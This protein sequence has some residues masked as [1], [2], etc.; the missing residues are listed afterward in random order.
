VTEQWISIEAVRTPV[1][2]YSSGALSALGAS[3]RD[4]GQRHPIT[5]WKDGTLIS[6][7]RR[8]RAALLLGSASM[9]AV[10]VDTI[11]DAAKRLLTD[12]QDDY[13]ALPMK[14]SEM[15]R[16]WELLRRLDEPAAKIRADEAR[17]RG[18]ELRRQTMRGQRPRG[19]TV[20]SSEDY[21]L[22]VLAPPFGLSESTARRLWA[23]Y[24]HAVGIANTTAEKADKARV[25]LADIDAGESSI[26]ANYERLITSRAAPAPRSRT[27]PVPV[28]AADAAR[29]R[30]AWAR[31]LPQLEG[32]VSGLVELGPPNAELTWDEVGPV[33]TRLAAVRRELEKMIKQMR[34]HNKS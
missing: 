29:Q 28:E 9:R 3:L 8:H 34:E 4:D 18:V 16:L 17:R 30:L 11:E 15:C 27:R 13:L 26:S 10:F 7:F 31:S 6:G 19:R 12:G 2:R 1:V 21:V 14:S 22:S 23:I 24:A 20:N 5:L 25:A 33:H 32:L